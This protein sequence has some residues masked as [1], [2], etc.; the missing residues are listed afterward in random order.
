MLNLTYIFQ[1]SEQVKVFE[2]GL[3]KSRYKPYVQQTCVDDTSKD[4]H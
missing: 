3:F 2:A 4:T 1:M